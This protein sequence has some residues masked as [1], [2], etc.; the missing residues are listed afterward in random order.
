MSDQGLGVPNGFLDVMSLAG[1]IIFS[2]TSFSAI[3]SSV[4][5]KKD[6]LFY[7]GT[8]VILLSLFLRSAAHWTYPAW[9][10]GVF[11]SVDQEMQIIMTL[12]LLAIAYTLDMGL[13]VF[14]WEGRL[15]QRE[16][17]SVPP[18]LIAS[19]R[20]VI[21]LV[22]ALII[23]QFVFDKPIT[24]LA[25]LSGALAVILG[26][27]AQATLGEIFA[28]IALALS[29]PFRIGDWVKIG[30]L[31]EG[32][33]IDMT[34]RMV[35]IETR[36]L[37]VLCIPNRSAADQTV[38]NFSY[39][40][41]AVRITETIWFPQSEEPPVI[42]DLLL[43]ALADTAGI[44]TNPQPSA[45]YRGAKEGV[46]EYSMRFYINDYKNKDNAIEAVWKSV[47]DHIARSDFVISFPRR[48]LSIQRNSSLLDGTS[49]PVQTA[50]AGTV[51]GSG[52]GAR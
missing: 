51:A 12:L 17:K 32:R 43:R 52:L 39:P 28:G 6:N 10:S 2:L 48:H 19:A 45:L 31:E 30:T 8:Q 27:S 47:I 33:V 11:D 22:A 40:N 5:V 9:F 50:A 35:T 44:L 23:L 26:L 42:Q 41:T 49:A 38:H 37:I 16:H 13:K 21:Y 29:R 1:I 36:D 4:F 15:R 24:A 14:V 25:A 46:S 3:L 34:W 20:V 18:L 7:L